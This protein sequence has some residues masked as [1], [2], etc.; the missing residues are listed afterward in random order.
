[1]CVCVCVCVYA[2]P[3]VLCSPGSSRRS[4]P[5]D[6]H[7]CPDWL[8]L[9]HPEGLW[10]DPRY[11]FSPVLS[12]WMQRTEKWGTSREGREHSNGVTCRNFGAPCKAGASPALLSLSL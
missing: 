12:D 10:A 11:V 2:A 9:G 6:C 4:D 5:N 7:R 3:V 8:P 1:M